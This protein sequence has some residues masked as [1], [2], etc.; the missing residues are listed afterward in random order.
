MTTKNVPGVLRKL[1]RAAENLIL[2]IDTPLLAGFQHLGH[3]RSLKRFRNVI[4]TEDYM[5]FPQFKLI[6]QIIDEAEVG[7]IN[8][9]ILEHTGYRY[10]GLAPIRSLL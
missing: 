4:V 6:R 9:I 7:D 2:V 5:N 8:R 3:L 1:K 10:H